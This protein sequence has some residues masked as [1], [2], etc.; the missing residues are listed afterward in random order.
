MNLT[1]F[2]QQIPKNFHQQFVLTT[3]QWPILTTELN[4]IESALTSELV[5]SLKGQL[6]KS[7]TV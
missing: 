3:T 1:F 2:R 5:K 4:G 7:Y 6:L